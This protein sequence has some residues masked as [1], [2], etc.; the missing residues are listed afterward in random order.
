MKSIRLLPLA[1]AAVSFAASAHTASPLPAVTDTNAPV[2]PLHYQSVFP[3]KTAA[4]DNQPTPDK[5]WIQVNR[6]LA[7][8]AAPVAHANHGANAMRPA[9]G[10][11]GAQQDKDTRQAKPTSDPHQGHHMPT[12]EPTK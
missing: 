2:A 10:Q 12:K 3:E 5:V 1:V 8:E 11:S 9:T 6:A 4:D 7:G